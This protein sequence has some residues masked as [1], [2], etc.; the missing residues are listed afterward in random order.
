MWHHVAQ[1]RNVRL[2]TSSVLA[3]CTG[4]VTDM[5]IR[6]SQGPI[7]IG[8]S[9]GLY[10]QLIVPSIFLVCWFPVSIPHI[11]WSSYPGMFSLYVGDGA[12]FASNFHVLLKT[13]FLQTR[14]LFRVLCLGVSVFVFCFCVKF[15]ETVLWLVV[16]VVIVIMG[17]GCVWLVRIIV[18]VIEF[19]CAWIILPIS[20]VFMGLSAVTGTILSFGRYCY[21]YRCCFVGIFNVLE[22]SIMTGFCDHTFY[23][24]CYLSCHFL[25]FSLCMSQCAP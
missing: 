6:K 21:R 16:L 3:G 15:T 25:G 17:P 13:P 20:I 1:R 23:R 14:V 24:L 12:W 2:D 7:T 22:K 19:L 10:T 9:L 18:V 4:L 8:L 11:K 5:T